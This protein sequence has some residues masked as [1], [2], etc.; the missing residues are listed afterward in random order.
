MNPRKLILSPLLF[1][2]LFLCKE[3]RAQTD[4]VQIGL[5]ELIWK[6]L[7]SNVQLTSGTK[8]ISGSRSEQDVADLPFTVIVIS[9]EEIRQNGY[10]T[11]TDVLK[12]LPGI[13]VSQPGSAL[14]GETFLMR[15][16]QGNAYAKILINDVPLKPFVA[17]G[18]PIGA[19]LPIRNAERI[20]VIYGPAATLYGADASAGVINIILKETDRPIY[21]QAALGFGSDATENLDVM[22]SGKLGK[23]K[24]II[25]FSVFGNYTS[26]SDRQIKYYRD[27]LYDPNLYP[28]NIETGQLVTSSPNFK[29]L[30]SS[31]P[32]IGNLPHLSKALGLNLSFRKFKFY[33][34]RFYRRDHSSLGL[35]P[36][37][38]SYANPLNFFGETIT[39]SGLGYE[40]VKKKFRFSANAGLLNYKTDPSSSYTYLF[41]FTN[42]VQQENLNSLEPV[43]GTVVSDSIR[44]EIDQTFYS[45]SRYSEANSLELNLDLLFGYKFKKY[46]ELAWGVNFQAGSGTP[47]RNFLVEPANVISTLD[48]LNGTYVSSNVYGDISGFAELYFNSERWNAIIGAQV[49]RRR[50]DF[51]VPD[52]PFFNPRLAL[53]YHYRE[54]LRFRFSTS[55]AFRYPSPYYSA[56]TYTL[57]LL[58][59]TAIGTGSDL[60]PERTVSVDF[61]TRWIPKKN[62]SLDVSVYFT[63]T[64]DFIRFGIEEGGASFGPLGNELDLRRIGYNN[65]N[66]SEANLYG[67]Q[68]NL[69]MKNLIP[70]IKLSTTLNLHYSIGREGANSFSFIESEIGPLNLDGLRSL[71]KFIGQ[72]DIKLQPTSKI[73]ILFENTYMTKSLTQNFFALQDDFGNNESILE[74]PGFYTLDALIGYRLNKHI[75]CFI[76]VH[77]VLNTKYAGIDATQDLDALLF[78]PQP[79][80]TTRVGVTYRID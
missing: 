46:F 28:A 48:N 14:E 60:K 3:L 59:P 74:N 31:T 67:I 53:Q 78:N 41:P 11:L 50:N 55:S 64:S 13:R 38:V 61:G 33:F 79:L 73:T 8:V 43:L 75:N 65:D 26:F 54:S 72:C 18:M 21:V 9:G 42:L 27:R 57:N 19:Q 20:E 29:G 40:L 22:F 49:F 36:L 62:I 30:D 4:S 23:G 51:D 80:R 39:T 56:S 1:L 32:T 34:H 76:K 7:R 6:D 25:K 63:R 71:P 47:I 70:A 12:R 52:R 66:T 35:N 58:N 15:G 17:S 5:S 44:N 2:T 69:V 24:R 68:S 45:D 77:N 37:A 10:F 16:L